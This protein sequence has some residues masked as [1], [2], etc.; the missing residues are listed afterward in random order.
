MVL[1]TVWCCCCD[2]YCYHEQ[3]LAVMAHRLKRLSKLAAKEVLPA[4][5][6]SL[7]TGRGYLLRESST[8][9]CYGNLVLSRGMAVP[10]GG[11][12]PPDGAHPPDARRERVRAGLDPP[13]RRRDPGTDPPRVLYCTWG[14]VWMWC[15]TLRGG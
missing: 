13:C 15:G 6:L 2:L 8:G 4:H 9:I 1:T 5:T 14:L 10:G 11:R 12:D 7:S 3:A